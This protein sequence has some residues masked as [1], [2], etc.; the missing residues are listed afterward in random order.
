M[1]YWLWLLC[2]TTLLIIEILVPHFVTVWFAIAAL[3]TGVV[4]FWA[5]DITLQLTVFSVSSM[6]LFSIGW[7]WLRKNMKMSARTRH[8]AEVVI[9]EA[10]TVVSSREGD[11]PGGMVRF[12]VPIRGDDVWEFVSNDKLIQGDRCVVTDVVGTKVRVKKA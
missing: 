2:G 6:I 8:A 9:G 5:G 11:T 12:Q 4:A 3:I 10:G 7:F 1:P